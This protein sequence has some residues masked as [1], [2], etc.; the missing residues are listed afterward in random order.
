[1]LAVSEQ[2]YYQMLICEWTVLLQLCLWKHESQLDE[3]KKVFAV[4][5]IVLI[6]ISTWIKKL[7]IDQLGL[8]NE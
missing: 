4:I 1:M 5:V 3:V 8:F 6:I 2:Y 7:E